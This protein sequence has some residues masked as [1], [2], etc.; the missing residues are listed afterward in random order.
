MPESILP[1]GSVIASYVVLVYMMLLPV[2]FRPSA[3]GNERNISQ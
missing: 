3:R 2:V 1:N